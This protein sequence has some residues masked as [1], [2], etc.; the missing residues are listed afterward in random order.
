MEATF[1]AAEGPRKAESWCKLT[2]FALLSR[3]LHSSVLAVLY[4][5]YWPLIAHNDLEI[6]WLSRPHQAL[7]G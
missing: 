5:S 3:L 4:V 2:R 6:G 1:L 7:L